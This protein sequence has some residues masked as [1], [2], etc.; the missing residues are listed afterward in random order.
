[1]QLRFAAQEHKVPGKDLLEKYELLVSLGY[2][3]IVLRS[4]GD[5]IFE[6]RLDELMAAKKAGVVMPATCTDMDHFMGDF[7]AERRRD[8]IE[9][10]K[11]HLSVM[12]KIGGYGAITPA[13]YAQHST[14]M[15]PYT[16]PRKPEEDREV[17][18]EALHELG[19]H[20]QTEGV[21]LLL[22]P[23][24]RYEDFMVN[25]LGQAVSLC[26]EVGLSSIKVVADLYHLN[27]EE[28][29]IPGAIRAAA[30]WLGWVDLSDTNRYQPGCG[31]QDWAGILT[32]L[33]DIGYDNYLTLEGRIRGDT[34]D[35]LRDTVTFI[36]K[37]FDALPA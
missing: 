35:A 14:N 29:S 22:E 26:E 4:Q 12:A 16:S 13:S 32:A 31:H 5:F 1:M 33:R 15:P 36:K 23:L 37:Q 17:L 34:V 18:L 9:N 19:K 11:S 7:K 6:K 20:A 24:N 28:D 8:A 25:N 10:L 3:G 27:I 21:T 2:E 30:K